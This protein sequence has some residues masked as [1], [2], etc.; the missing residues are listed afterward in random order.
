MHERGSSEEEDKIYVHAEKQ[1]RIIF[2]VNRNKAIFPLQSS[3]TSR[4]PVLHIPENTSPK[5]D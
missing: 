4:K 2:A 5:I 3:N 1:I